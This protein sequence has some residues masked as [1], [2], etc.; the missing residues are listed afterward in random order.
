MFFLDTIVLVTCGLRSCVE[1]SRTVEIFVLKEFK[2]EK[3]MKAEEQ[4]PESII[5]Q[6]CSTEDF[7]SGGMVYEKMRLLEE[8]RQPSQSED[9]SESEDVAQC[10]TAPIGKH[11]Q[12]RDPKDRPPIEI[13]P[14]D[15]AT[16]GSAKVKEAYTN[17]KANGYQCPAETLEPLLFQKAF[18]E[19]CV[20]IGPKPKPLQR[21]DTRVPKK[22]VGDLHDWGLLT[23]TALSMIICFALLFTVPKPTG[24]HRVIID[25]RP[26]NAQLARPPY[27]RFFQPIELVAALR[28]LETFTGSSWDIRHFSYRLTLPAYIGVFYGLTL[29]SGLFI[30]TQV[31]M[32]STHGPAWASSFAFCIVAYIE[33][34]ESALGLKVPPG[35]IPTVLDILVAGA[36][37]AAHRHLCWDKQS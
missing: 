12:K 28:L 23:K 21:R 31:P 11:N 1:S 4:D 22:N 18:Y 29:I 17:L 27:F 32:G 33:A 19:R 8:T 35:I 24:L 10:D 36:V 5:F 7:H 26:G 16:L 37:S 2:K 15:P 25:G 13:D 34:R 14:M 30:P 6:W 20:L 9:D 3:K